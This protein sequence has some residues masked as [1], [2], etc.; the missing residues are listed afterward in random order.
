MPPP[1]LQDEA[2]MG[3]RSV[4]IIRKVW[5]A[6]HEHKFI[7]FSRLSFILKSDDASSFN[8]PTH[9]WS[10]F[11]IHGFQIYGFTYLLRCI[12][13][14]REKKNLNHPMAT[15]SLRWTRRC[16]LPSCFTLWRSVLF[17][18]HLMPPSLHFCVFFLM[19]LLL[20][21]APSIVW[22]YRPVLLSTRGLWYA[23]GRIDVC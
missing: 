16:S 13:M 4:R 14:C 9:R 10:T 5:W 6:L 7:Q 12:D 8:T 18:A 11:I 19:I 21:T 2:F 23:L 1:S 15:L 20:K 22:K 3:L 17:A